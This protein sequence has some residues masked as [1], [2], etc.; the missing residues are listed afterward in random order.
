MVDAGSDVHLWAD[1]YPRTLDNI[2]GV[3]GE[4]AQKVA[5][6]LKA[7]LTPAESASVA[8]LQTRN[9]AAFDL[10][11]KAEEAAYLANGSWQESSFAASDDYYRQAIALDPDFA[12]ALANRAYY[13]MDRHWLSR[14]L[15]DGELADVVVHGGLTGLRLSWI[16]HFA[17]HD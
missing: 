4:V 17:C 12:L 10:F 1:A 11:L 5:D 6:A 3:E 14:K 2:F 13:R 16:K 8:N 15:T 9:A 7:K